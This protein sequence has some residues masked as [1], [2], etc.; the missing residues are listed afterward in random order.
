MMIARF[1]VTCRFI[2][3]LDRYS[4]PYDSDCSSCILNLGTDTAEA[5]KHR[6]S[7]VFKGDKLGA[8]FVAYID[9]SLAGDVGKWKA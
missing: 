4:S 2:L 8:L 3:L 7:K 5:K 1:K 9:T 6:Y